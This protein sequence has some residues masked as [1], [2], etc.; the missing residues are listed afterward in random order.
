MTL[1]ALALSLLKK[2]HFARSLA[3]CLPNLAPFAATKS[4][5]IPRVPD[6]DIVLGNMASAGA[7]AKHPKVYTP[8]RIVRVIEKGHMRGHVGRM[9][10]SGSIADVCAELDRLAAREAA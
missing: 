2:I 6:A 5:P 9:V 10:I 4:A 8:L 1:Y 3:D 7:G